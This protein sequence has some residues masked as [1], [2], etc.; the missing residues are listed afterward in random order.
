ML[1]LIREDGG[2]AAHV[3]QR[4]GLNEKQIV[5]LVKQVHPADKSTDQIPITLS[6]DLKSLLYLAVDEARRLGHHYIGTEHLLLGLILQS[7]SRAV[8]VLQQLNVS[9]ED[10]RQNV[11]QVIREFPLRPTS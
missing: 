4:L 1:G 11:Y 10:V 8:D 9:L 2:I 6:D 5:E 3:L 7:N